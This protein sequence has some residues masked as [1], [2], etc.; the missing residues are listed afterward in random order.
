MV[1]G[2]PGRAALQVDQQQRNRGWGH[3][4]DARGLAE[5]FGTMLRQ[6]LLDLARQAAD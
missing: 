3:A 1:L 4:L 2:R 6:L 5:R